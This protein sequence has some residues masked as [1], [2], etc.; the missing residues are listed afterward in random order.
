MVNY[1]TVD[2][3]VDENDG[4]LS[5]GDISLRE[6][7]AFA[8][9]DGIVNFAPGLTGTISLD[10][11][12]GQLVV[13][14]PLTIDGPGADVL[15]VSGNHQTRVLAIEN[16]VEIN[17]LTIANGHADVGAGIDVG[18]TASVTILDSALVNNTAAI[19]G[20]GL[21]ND[22]GFVSLIDSALSGNTAIRGGG[23]FNEVGDAGGTLIVEG[24][25]FS[26]NRAGF[27]GAIYAER[28]DVAIANS[29][30]SGNFADGNYSGGVYAAYGAGIYNY[31]GE[32]TLSDS[33]VTGN[34][35]IGSDSYGGGIYNNDGELVINRSSIQDN[36]VDGL[37]ATGGGIASN[38]GTVTLSDSIV[39]GN[40]IEGGFDASGGGI[41]SVNTTLLVSDS[42]ITAN[43]AGAIG[44]NGGGIYSSGGPLTVNDSTISGNTT[45]LS[46]GSIGGS[47]GGGIYAASGTVTVNRSTVSGNVTGIG[48]R[49]GFGGGIAGGNSNLIVSNSTISGNTAEGSISGTGGGI[50]TYSHLAVS[51]STITDNTSS[52]L[53]A[54]GYG[55]GIF[56][57]GY[58]GSGVATVT[59]SIVAGNTSNNAFNDIFGNFGSQGNNLIGT[60]NAV[61][62][63]NQPTDITGVIDPGLDP[64]TDNGGPTQTHAL[65]AASLALDAGANSDGLATDQRGNGFDRVVNGQADIG[66]FEVQIPA[67][68]IGLYNAATDTLISVIQEGDEFLASTLMGQSLSIAA[69]VPEGSPFEGQVESLF[70]DLNEG[71]VTRTENIEPYALF[72]DFNGDIQSGML[73]TGDNTIAFDLY[74][75]NGLQGDLLATITRNFAI[76]DDISG[77]AAI[78]VGLYDADTDQLIASIEDGTEILAS[79]VMNRSLNIAAFIPPDSVFA[80][81]VESVFLDLNNGQ[82]TRTENF[83]PYSLFGDVLGDFNGGSLALGENAIA[84][85]LYA[86]NGLMGDLI[87]SVSGSFTIVDNVT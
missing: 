26:E 68:E 3:L 37:G 8:E 1:L 84:F 71:L 82:V 11:L 7:I 75:E 59:S 22:E 62:A 72:G 12:L 24:S 41:S 4:N 38:G 81:Q 2:T 10:P 61:G 18:S 19:N 74:S 35:S 67:L 20:G 40:A 69:I 51:N 73:P 53:G 21:Y 56:S 76:A 34:A 78:E 43:D 29:T 15:T 48:G 54:Y 86:E 6:A 17:E 87:G 13:N 46:N 42:T 30:L 33:N 79:E 31:S 47:A 52:G 83:E 80:D 36:S 77:L 55:G 44:A 85:D 57:S 5:I 25:T 58:I 32:L 39:S 28:G 66:A 63:F 50:A 9:N 14:K 45:R 23:L 64:L 27:G 60:G 65:Q 70:L 49:G 16:D